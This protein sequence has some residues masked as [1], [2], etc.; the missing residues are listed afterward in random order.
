MNRRDFLKSTALGGLALGGAAALLAGLPPRL[1]AALQE[2]AAATAAA[3]EEQIRWLPPAAGGKLPQVST[4]AM[5]TEPRMVDEF[6][7]LRDDFL[8]DVLQRMIREFTG[9]RRT[10]DAWRQFF[11]RDDIIAL[12][13]D[14]LAS[15]ELGT[16]AAFARAIIISLA[17]NGFKADRI[18]LID[19]PQFIGEIRTRRSPIVLKLHPAPRGYVNQ[20]LK[21]TEE[22]TTH[23]RRAL[24]T[25]TAVLNVPTIKHHRQLGMACGLT[26]IT[27]GMINNP[28]AFVANDAGDPGLASLAAMKEIGGKHRL[29]LVNGIRGIYDRGP[30]AER[31]DSNIWAQNTVLMAADV[32]AADAKAQELLDAARQARELQSLADGGPSPS[33]LAAAE[34]LGL[35][36]ARMARIK[37]QQINM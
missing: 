21:V 36:H 9:E 24:D 27:L 37:V 34:R 11:R 35:G 5:V 14:P 20:P 28:G 3:A 25:A 8:I 30:R 10:R 29:T 6:G 12:K 23:L 31:D 13:F 18:M 33:Y 19:P 1:L 17:E 4:L 2:D 32:V 7:H 16:N 22:R 15:D 26:N